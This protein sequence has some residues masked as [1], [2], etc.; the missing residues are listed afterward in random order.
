MN[1]VLY[2]GL[3]EFAD[4]LVRVSVIDA[5]N[6][7]EFIKDNEQLKIITVFFDTEEGKFSCYMWLKNKKTIKEYEVTESIV[8]AWAYYCQLDDPDILTNLKTCSLLSYSILKGL[9]N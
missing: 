5:K 7:K 4:D 8:D 1:L 6:V 2:N 3:N 9:K